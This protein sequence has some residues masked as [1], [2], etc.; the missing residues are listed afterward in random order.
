MV[1][2]LRAEMGSLIM[3]E[4]YLKSENE[5]IKSRVITFGVISVVIMAVSTYTQIS[6]LKNFFRYK[7]II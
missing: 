4:E 3:Q 1:E 7:K 2:Q 6:Y 5:L